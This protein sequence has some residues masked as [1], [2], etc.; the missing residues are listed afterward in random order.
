MFESIHDYRPLV[1][2]NKYIDSSTLLSQ[3][4]AFFVFCKH[5]KQYHVKNNYY[6]KLKND[7]IIN[8]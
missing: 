3:F 5:S 1:K 2:D 6:N 8:C 7:I 4:K